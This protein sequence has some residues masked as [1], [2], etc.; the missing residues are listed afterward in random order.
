[1]FSR[2]IDCKRHG[3]GIEVGFV[4][5]CI[6]SVS[7]IRS[8]VGTQRIRRTRGVVGVGVTARATGVA[9]V[10]VRGHVGLDKRAG[11]RA[12]SLSH[13][14]IREVGAIPATHDAASSKVGQVEGRA[15]VPCAK[16]RANGSKEPGVLVARYLLS[17]AWYPSGRK[18][19]GRYVRDDGAYWHRVSAL[20][21]IVSTVKEMRH[22]I[23]APD[24]ST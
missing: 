19:R 6:S 3:T 15:T 24:I 2:G 9:R 21:P 18:V 13:Y 23:E 17:P 14:A 22:I 10:R 11:L 5:R 4:G 16:P 7:C 1:M 12:S 8:V 20:G